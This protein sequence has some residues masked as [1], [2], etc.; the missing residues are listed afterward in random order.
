M[1][2][3][4]TGKFEQANNLLSKVPDNVLHKQMEDMDKVKTV[5]NYLMER[6]LGEVS[7]IANENILLRAIVIKQLSLVN[8][9]IVNINILI[10]NGLSIL[11]VSTLNLSGGQLANLLVNENRDTFD[12]DTLT[13]C[14][15]QIKSRLPESLRER[16]NSEH[17]IKVKQSLYNVLPS[18]EQLA[19]Q[20]PPKLRQQ[21]AEGF[22]DFTDLSSPFMNQNNDAPEATQYDMFDKT[23]HVAYKKIDTV[24]EV[25]EFHRLLDAK[26]EENANAPGVNLSDMDIGLF[27]QSDD[28]NDPDTRA[29]IDRYLKE[30]PGDATMFAMEIKTLMSNS[31]Y[32]EQDRAHIKEQ[33][34]KAKIK[35]IVLRKDLDYINVD[36]LEEEDMNAKY[37]DRN[38]TLMVNPVNNK[39][40]YYDNHSRSLKELPPDSEMKPVSIKEVEHLLKSK[41]LSDEE[42][43][44]TLIYLKN[45]KIGADNSGYLLGGSGGDDEEEQDKSTNPTQTDM[46]MADPLNEAK[47]KE[48][49]GKHKVEKNNLV[50]NL[51]IFLVVMVIVV[52]LIVLLRNFKQ[53]IN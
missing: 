7:L 30:D 5:Y 2:V 26:R 24:G 44:K 20:E 41:K 40:Y 36:K 17:D 21:K 33:L 50:R 49:E 15:S 9:K 16:F 38:P 37:V 1:D 31:T 29:R 34:I 42:I 28:Y 8:M 32:D 39:Y 52:I 6:H 12:L 18:A 53:S 51:T 22:Q 43:N 10:F 13:K 45:D 46:V 11:G 47:N 14:I 48:I 4:K 27:K 19:I 23:G 25:S 3:S 35:E